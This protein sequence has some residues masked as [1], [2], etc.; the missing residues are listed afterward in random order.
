MPPTSSLPPETPVGPPGT[1]RPLRIA[2]L[3][4]LIN[5]L[6]AAVKLA[7]GILGNSYALVAD[8]LESLTDVAASLITSAGLRYAARPPDEDHPYG[9]GRAESIAGLIVSAM[10]FGAGVVIAIQAVGQIRD[11]GVGPAPF[12]LWVLIGVV[13]VKETV[14]RLMRRVARDTGSPAVTADAW[15]NR[16]DAITSAA[17]AIGIT[18]ALVGGEGYES[19][20]DWAALVAA[21]IVL[22]NAFTILLAPWHELM[23]RQS[24]ELLAQVRAAAERVPGVLDVEKLYARKTGSHYHV[25][26]HLHVD[27]NMTV[28]DAHELSGRVK[29]AV[30]REVRHIADVLIHIEPGQGGTA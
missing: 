2:L 10:L 13:I 20:D 23:D 29:G 9:H 26:M 1:P 12:T 7:A 4:L 24:P 11:P 17:A 5:T 25:D 19:A 6:L 16:A 22:Y 14:F 30:R 27:P 8:A 21:A 28:H 18:V 15:H 3:G